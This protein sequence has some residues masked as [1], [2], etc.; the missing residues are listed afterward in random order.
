[1]KLK[2]SCPIFFILLFAI[3]RFKPKADKKGQLPIL[4]VC[5]LPAYGGVIK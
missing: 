3:Y 5:G 4:I 1:M 2:R